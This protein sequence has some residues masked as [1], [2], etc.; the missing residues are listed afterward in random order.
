MVCLGISLKTKQRT[1]YSIKVKIDLLCGMFDLQCL[2]WHGVVYKR[3]LEEKYIP[4]KRFF[5]V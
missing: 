1:V 2:H 4:N 5:R 3:I